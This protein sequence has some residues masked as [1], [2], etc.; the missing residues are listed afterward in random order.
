[1]KLEI[2]FLYLKKSHW[3]KKKN[4]KKQWEEK[5]TPVEWLGSL[6]T[7]VCVGFPKWLSCKESACQFRRHKRH[8]FNPWV[9]KTPWRRKQQLKPVFL[10]VKSHG[11]RILV[12][13]SPW[14][15]Q[16]L[17]TSEQLNICVCFN[18]LGMLI[19][20]SLSVIKPLFQKFSIWTS[21]PSLTML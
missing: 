15:H 7:C 12:G 4:S 14:G 16:E 3:E 17:D 6:C 8:G 19:N 1:M 9:R 2:I 20:H 11:Q 5:I 18:I 21:V 10:P 13:Y